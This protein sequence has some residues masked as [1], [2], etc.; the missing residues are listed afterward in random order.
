MPRGLLEIKRDS[1]TALS[2]VFKVDFVWPASDLPFF[3][4]YSRQSMATTN[5]GSAP[6][7]QDSLYYQEIM[8]AL[9]QSK[10]SY[11]PMDRAPCASNLASEQQH[12]PNP[13]TMRCGS[14]KL[15]SYCSKECQRFHWKTHK[16]DCEHPMRSP[17]WTPAWMRERRKASYVGT[18]WAPFGVH[19]RPPVW[20]W[21]NTPAID[22]LRLG[23]NEKD[24]RRDYKICLAAS[25]DL[26]HVVKTVNNLPDD[27]SGNLAFVINDKS[28]Q[29]SARNLVL[30]LILGTISD[31][32]LAADLAL[33][34]W[35]SI[36][37]PPEYGHRLT[38]TI[39]AFKIEGKKSEGCIST[40]LGAKSSVHLLSN[41]TWED[42][43]AGALAD[44]IGPFDFDGEAVQREHHRIRN[45]PQR[46]DHRDRMYANLY[47]SHRVALGRF[48]ER[49]IVLPFG[50]IDAHFASPNPSL[51][52]PQCLWLQKDFAD[53]LQGWNVDEVVQ[54]GKKHGTTSEDLYGCLYFFLTDELQKFARRLQKF[55]ISFLVTALDA[56]VLPEVIRE[57]VYS[58]HGLP[59][60]VLFDRIAVSN[61]ID[62]GYVGLRAVLSTWEPL[63]ARKPKATIVGYFMNWEQEQ[64]DA[65][66]SGI[67]QAAARAIMMKLLNLPY[68]RRRYKDSAKE[69]KERGDG[70]QPIFSATQDAE[71]AYDTSKPFEAYLQKK[72]LANIL[73]QLGLKRKRKH[74]IVPH[75][76]GISLD[77]PAHALP[78]YANDESWYYNTTFAN[79]SWVERFVEFGR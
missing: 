47:P 55:S 17:K 1:P 28:A 34:F 68:F 44:Y 30:L 49:G 70:I 35:Y 25:G 56:R 48:R 31:S 18:A 52:S 69:A 78:S 46:Q 29:V 2:Y 58:A 10:P 40:P 71:V 36:L 76:M 19:N 27:Y 64:K 51:F 62:D 8:T 16:A 54:A 14:C 59:S 65:T 37:L 50:A 7:L 20:L 39:G 66:T 75:R 22:L 41:A 5:S 60:T 63:L 13:G 38:H 57:D 33:H 43:L 3:P 42:G 11:P 24:A 72:D 9:S 77:S 79:H 23:K 15:V 32:V 74:T 45:N 21:G 53:P 67:G 61:I 73:L 4:V 12:C 6:Q 26:R